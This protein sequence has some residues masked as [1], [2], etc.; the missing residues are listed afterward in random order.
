MQAFHF[1]ILQQSVA[2]RARVAQPTIYT[3]QLNNAALVFLGRVVAFVEV[4]EFVTALLKF[5]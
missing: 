3:L 4:L 2:Q 5:F 1:N